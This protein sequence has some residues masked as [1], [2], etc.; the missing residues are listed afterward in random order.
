MKTESEKYGSTYKK[1]DNKKHM[2]FIKRFVI[3][4]IFVLY[5]YETQIF[6]HVKD[7]SFSVCLKIS[8]F[9]LARK[10]CMYDLNVKHS[11]FQ[12]RFVP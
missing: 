12:Y 11:A 1:H 2:L 5:N 7:T 4:I 8:A 9:F 6:F 10:S 3:H